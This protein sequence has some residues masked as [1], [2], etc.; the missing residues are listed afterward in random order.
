MPNVNFAAAGSSPRAALPRNAHSL[1]NRAVSWL[2]LLLVFGLIVFRAS[3]QP[4]SHDE[5]LTWMWFLDGG[6]YHLLSFNANNHALFTLVCTPVVKLFGVSELSLRAPSVVA[7][8]GYLVLVYLLCQELF[9]ES[10]LVP[11]TVGMLSLNPT[12]TDFMVLARGYGMGVMFLT[13][14]MFVLARLTAR[15]GAGLSERRWRRGCALASMLLALAVAANLTEI[16]PAVCLSVA[17]AGLTLPSPIFALSNRRP[18][19]TFAQW[20]LAPGAVL[21][22]FILRPFLIQARPS[23]FY[24]GHKGAT[25][26]LRDIFNSF[27]LYRWTPDLYSSLG[28]L[29]LAARSWQQRAS[30]VGVFVLLPSLLLFLLLGVMVCLRGGVKQNRASAVRIPLFGGAAIGCAGLWLLL[31]FAVGLRYPLSRTFLFAIPL[32]T[33]ATVLIAQE[34]AFRFQRR[35]IQAVGFVVAAALIADYAAALHTSYFRYTAYDTI[36]RDLFLAIA[37]GVHSRGLTQVRVGGTWGLP[38]HRRGELGA[39]VAA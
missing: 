28:S 33:V 5:A 32:F 30:D 6:V 9:G 17:F 8:G 2:I 23:M 16:I 12:L 22:L 18:L 10:I 36:S 25:D 29:T 39:S 14:A 38:S 24:A 13:A 7:A 20:F 34:F 26:S 4:I 15:Q 11:I 27:F 1:T 31:H 21:G 37:Q 3:V 19:R 35:W